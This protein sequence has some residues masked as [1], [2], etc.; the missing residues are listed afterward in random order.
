MKLISTYT[1][2][3]TVMMAAPVA[4]QGILPYLPKHTIMAMSAPDLTT[5]IAEFQKMP[6]AKMWEEEEVQTFFADMMDMAK[7]S[8]DEGMAMAKEQHAAGM[9][10]IDPEQL[11]KL[12][13]DGGTLAVT[14]L[15]MSTSPFGPMPEFG[16]IAHIDFGQSAPTWNMLIQMGMAMMAAEAGDEMERTESKIGDISVI[17]MTPADVPVKMG[18]HMAMVPGGILL[19][20][21]A[22]DVKGIVT[23]MTNKTPALTTAPGYA[24]ATKSLDTA[25]AELEMY[26]AP[27]GLIDF[28]M[29]ALGMALEEEGMSQMVDMEGVERALQALG[30]RNLGTL[31][32][33]TSYGNG[34][35]TT[36][37]ALARNGSGTAATK[38][39]DMSF[40]KWVPKDAVAFGSGTMNISSYYD[41]VVKA[42]QAYDENMANMMLGQLAQMEQA[43]GFKLRDDLI[44]SMGDHYIT[45]SMPMSTISSTPEVAYLLKVTNPEKLV[46]SLKKISAMTDGAIEIEEG[47]K[48][49]VKSY[50]LRI[51][52]DMDQGMAMGMGVNPFDM[53]NPTFA[54]KDGYMV[55]GFSASDV[56][57]VFK[58]MDREDNP[59]GDIRGNKEFMA[60]K[61]TIPANVTSVRFVDNKSDF[62]SIYQLITGVLAFV[63]MPEDVP[64]DMSLLPDSETL[65]QHLF[66][67][68][69]YS[70]SDANGAM[71]VSSSPFG[72]EMLAVI[73]GV[74]A[75][76]AGFAAFTVG[77]M[78]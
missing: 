61:D 30:L 64:I 56:K 29:T 26:M 73:A 66:G 35:C 54:F 2:A 70:K 69:S 4:A 71:S 34:K 59:K 39:I 38:S 77:E 31:A 47:T 67:T 55:M 50:Q 1:L 23:N 40:L 33:S 52:V 57:R 8:I 3:A 27:N 78:R 25:G 24:A 12:R 15:G 65:T 22:D 14:S 74:A 13:I 42:M 44:G 28:G 60:V 9:L 20:T 53:I 21:L 5:S 17:S 45:W 76:V 43:M 6:L 37:S 48:R 72:P 46:D 18:I 10:P 51:N 49:G 68:I 32:A 11:M 41:R 58:R 62:E 19:G 36:K 7:D 16:L 75:G 63:P